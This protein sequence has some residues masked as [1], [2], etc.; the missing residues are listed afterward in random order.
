[1]ATLATGIAL[2]E[3]PSLD[4][5]RKFFILAIIIIVLVA[6]GIVLNFFK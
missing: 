5:M 6:V 2:P 4:Y 1:M 3:L